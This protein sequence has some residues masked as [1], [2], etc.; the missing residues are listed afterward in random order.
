ML[1]KSNLD[2]AILNNSQRAAAVHGDGPCRV[3][4][5]PGSGKTRVFLH[6][7]SSTSAWLYLIVIK[8]DPA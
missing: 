4:A 1:L 7:F 2:L 8:R 3:I 6:K 5:G